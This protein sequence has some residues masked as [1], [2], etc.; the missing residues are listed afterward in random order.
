MTSD[1]SRACQFPWHAGTITDSRDHWGTSAAVW[2]ADNDSLVCKLGPAEDPENR[3]NARLC[4]AAPDLLAA[5]KGL[6]LAMPTEVL[7]SLTYDQTAA[8]LE[9][10]SDGCG[11]IARAE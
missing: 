8:L 11:A 4:A 5:C 3:A 6:V 1:S 10:L 7:F 2:A 9:A